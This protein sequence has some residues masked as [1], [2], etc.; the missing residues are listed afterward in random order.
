MKIFK[1]ISLSLLLASTSVSSFL[2]ATTVNK[3]SLVNIPEK[4]VCIKH[5]DATDA[6]KYFSTATIINFEV[7]KIGSADE[8]QKLIKILSADANVESCNAGTV[9]GDFSAF[10]LSLKSAKNKAYFVALIKKA[11]LLHIKINNNA[12]VEA[13]KI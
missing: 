2:N 11:G 3:N 12:A 8:V 1:I 6:N 7:Y 9:T 4:T 10:T 13:D 5:P